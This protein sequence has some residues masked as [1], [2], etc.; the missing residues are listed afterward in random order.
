MRF[1]RT[2]LLLLLL[3]TVKENLILA[4]PTQMHVTVGVGSKFLM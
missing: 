1:A 3:I 4:I 2:K